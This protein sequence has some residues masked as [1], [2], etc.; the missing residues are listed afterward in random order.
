M[1]DIQRQF[2][3][4]AFA[5]KALQFGEFQLKSGRISPYFFNSGHFC[6]GNDL[7]LLGQCY[8]H[9]WHQHHINGDC[10]FGPA[11]KGIPLACTLSMTLAQQGLNRAWCFNRK[12]AKPHG[13]GGQL[14]GS[15]LHGRVVLVDDVIS[16]GKAI[17]ESVALIQAT[18]ATISAIL[19][20]LDRQERGLSERSTLNELQALLDIPIYA[21]INIQDL[22]THLQDTPALQQHTVAI[23]AYRRKYAGQ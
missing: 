22:L 12:E 15:P 18:G 6:D 20:M 8:A 10:I 16:S 21:I 9:L 7:D 5:K 17:R 4:Q 19:V 1:H 3:D 11:Y 13:E 2:I 14:V 23:Q